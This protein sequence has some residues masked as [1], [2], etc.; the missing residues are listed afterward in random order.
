MAQIV[1]SQVKLNNGQLVTPQT[2][3]WYDSQQFWGG[4][5]STPG[6]I[7]PQS[8]QQGAGQPV[9][10][11]VIAQTNPANVPYIQKQQQQY[12][13][14]PPQPTQP[15]GSGVTPG[16]STSGT[17]VNLAGLP[18]VTPTI[19]LPDLYNS[20]YKDS[21][22][23]DLEKKYSDMTTS[24]NNAQSKIN[25]NPFLSEASRVG[26]IQKL[27]T[28]YQNATANIKNDIATKKADVEMKL[29]LATKQYDIN[30]QAAKDALST[31]NTLLDSG[32]LNNASGEDIANITRST[33]ISSTMI[34]S[35]IDASKAKNIKSQVI[36][37][38]NDAGVV[39][40]SVINPD[41]GE[42]IKQSSLGAIGNQQGTGTETSSTKNVQEQFTNEAGTLQG[43]QTNAGWVG[44]FPLLVAKYAPMMSLQDIY[45]MYMNTDLGKKYGAPGE[46]AAEIKE[47]YDTYRGA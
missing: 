36:T 28:D 33:G 14:Q 10:N 3:G 11:E 24:F 38:T 42:I 39:T 8:N 6:A 18:S 44:Q 9:S 26:R 22:V 20:L 47:I 4:T 2:G 34:Q 15:M 23:S 1:G 46:S 13:P 27:A 32:A 21:G 45:K 37:S 43:Q 16:V 31:F 7:N 40:V 17:G 19:N 5:L 12:Q 29:N 25:D 35:A 30:S 41:T